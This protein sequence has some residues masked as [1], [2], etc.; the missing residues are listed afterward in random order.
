MSGLVTETGVRPVV[1][2]YVAVPAHAKA[3]VAEGLLLEWREAFAGWARCEGYVLGSVFTDVRGRGEGG[4]YGL[5][6]YLRRDGVVGVVV[7]DV[8]HLTHVR[9]LAGADR[10]VV[11]RFLRA[12]VLTVEPGGQGSASGQSESGGQG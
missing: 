12:A 7:P 4:L 1:A 11:Q 5:A 8:G 2:G 10:H 9:C 3:E 6:K